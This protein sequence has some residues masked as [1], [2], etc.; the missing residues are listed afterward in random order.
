M[1]GHTRNLLNTVM[2]ALPFQQ[3]SGVHSR[4]NSRGHLRGH[5]NHRYSGHGRR[6]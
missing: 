3:H 1:Q 4:G 5:S 6:H 2:R